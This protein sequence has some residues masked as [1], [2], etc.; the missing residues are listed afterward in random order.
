MISSEILENESTY[1]QQ[2]ETF[3]TSHCNPSMNV[4][5]FPTHMKSSC[6]AYNGLQND[7]TFD[8]I[9]NSLPNFQQIEKPKENHE[10]I[11][12]DLRDQSSINENKAYTNDHSNIFECNSRSNS[13]SNTSNSNSNEQWDGLI[14]TREDQGLYVSDL[15]K[16]ITA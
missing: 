6:L 1:D 9:N 4:S 12:N 5:N 11:S 15:Q 2:H 16:V 13:V 3:V 7:T 8:Q 10:I 14:D